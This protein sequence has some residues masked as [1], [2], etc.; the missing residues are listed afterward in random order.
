MRSYCTLL[1]GEGHPLANGLWLWRWKAIQNKCSYEDLLILLIIHITDSLTSGPGSPTHTIEE[2]TRRH[3]NEGSFYKNKIP[4]MIFNCLARQTFLGNSITFIWFWTCML[5]PSLSCFL[6]VMKLVGWRRKEI[7]M[8]LREHSNAV[9][10][11]KVFCFSSLF[12]TNITIV[13]IH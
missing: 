4:H 8:I 7:E 13:V 1:Q 12:F 9:L 11:F 5:I 3:F 6:S 10:H 2:R